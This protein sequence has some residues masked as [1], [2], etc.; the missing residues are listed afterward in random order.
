[1]SALPLCKISSHSPA[2]VINPT[3]PVI[4]PD[5]FFTFSAKDT[6]Y[7]GFTSILALYTLPPLEQS[8][9]STP[10]CFNT[11]ANL[12]ESSIVQPFSDHSEADILTNNGLFAGHT[13]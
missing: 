10:F 9:R 8:T 1:M 3:A 5:S 11:F 12:T 7:S 13:L 4:I 2:F 6:W